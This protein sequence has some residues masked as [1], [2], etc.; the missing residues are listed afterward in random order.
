MIAYNLARFGEPFEFGVRYQLTHGSMLDKRVCGVHSIAEL[1]RLAN[2]VLHYLFTAPVIRSRFPFVDLPH[3]NLDAAVVWQSPGGLTEAVAGIAPLIP[4]TIV[5]AVFAVLLLLGLD[6][7]QRDAGTRAALQVLAGG[8]LVL[9]GVSS[10]WWVVSRYA[11]DFTLLIVAAS[12]VCLEVGAAH[13]ERFGIRIPPLRVMVA[14]LACLSIALGVLLGFMGPGSAFERLHPDT[15]HH[16]A[17]WFQ[18]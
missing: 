7:G 15:F 16:V 4:L 14:A 11:L 8:G 3:A 10:C 2:H 5:A 18:Q 17:H 6:R 1:G 12:I 9:I 13:L